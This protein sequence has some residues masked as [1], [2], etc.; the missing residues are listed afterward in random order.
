MNVPSKPK[1]VPPD[2]TPAAGPIALKRGLDVKAEMICD[3]L[4]ANKS[5][6]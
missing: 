1:S 6:R 5:L 2:G 4:S 3:A